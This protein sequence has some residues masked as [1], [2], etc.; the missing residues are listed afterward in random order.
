PDFTSSDLDYE[1]PVTDDEKVV[2]EVWQDV[3]QLE[4]VGVTD[5]F[6]RIGGDSILSIRLVARMKQMGYQVV[7]RDIFDFKNIREL[8]SKTSSIVLEEEKQYEPFSLVTTAL[9][10]EIIKENNLLRDEIEDIYPVAYL[11]AGM[12]IEALFE[13][14][15][16]TYH[17]VLSF[18]V[19]TAFDE[20]D[21]LRNWEPLVRKHELLRSS[22]VTHES[23]FHNVIHRMIDL[24]SKLEL[25]N[26]FD[27]LENYVE[28][29][30]IRDFDH[31]LPGIFRLGIRTESD[32]SFTLALSIPHAIT[33]G[34]SVASVISE[35]V[36][37]YIHGK[38]VETVEKPLYG[39]YISKEQEALTDPTYATFWKEY[40]EEYEIKSGNFALES[41]GTTETIIID[42]ALSD[43]MNRQV[44][45]LAKTLE[46][47]P[48]IIFLGI[49]NLVLGLYHH[50]QDNVIGTVVNNRLK[51]EGGDK[52]FGLHL[53]TIPVRLKTLPELSVSAYL[54][55]VFENKLALNAYKI[56]PYARIKSDAAI[57]K[58][59][60]Q[61]SFNYVNFHVAEDNYSNQSFSSA[62]SVAKTSI[63]FTL[64]I[65]RHQDDF[66]LNLN[67][68]SGFI[69][70]DAAKQF[71][72]TFKRYL[73]QVI[74]SPEEELGNLRHMDDG[75]YDAIVHQ[76][77]ARKSTIDDNHTIA[78]CFEQQV[79]AYADKKALVFRNKAFDYKELNE[80]ANQLARLIIQRYK[81]IHGRELPA[82]EPIAMC[83]NRSS[84]MLIGMIAVLKTGG[85]FVP[86][87]PNYPQ[88]R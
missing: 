39:G 37:A 10:E 45:E 63:P 19:N 21:F 78:A 32:D 28:S 12:L 13:K 87:D 60:Y 22:I 62:Y 61:C 85:A 58:D 75:Q 74:T 34:W 41:G 59:L 23:G 76:L 64:H 57:Q 25:I 40:L 11:Q 31:A 35:F 66:H 73:D 36:D 71:I 8:L 43:Q 9:K 56:Y 46:I 44:I 80:K 7:E 20:I 5:N 82:G 15:Q 86:I 33:D 27:S 83:L 2:C 68:D 65:H 17:D 52:V 18:E 69:D 48:D 38:P 55:Y 49:Y 50:A 26:D 81:H 30:K 51:E 54:K 24:P 14:R 29:E 70:R 1:A 72:S 42:E 6:F 79:I 4:R 47:S 16:D 67:T 84:E 3:L 88:D 77:N 53:N